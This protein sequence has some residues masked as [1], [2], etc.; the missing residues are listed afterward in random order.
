MEY[1]VNAINEG[2][3]L[4]VVVTATGSGDR[5]RTTVACQVTNTA[6]LAAEMIRWHRG[7]DEERTEAAERLLAGAGLDSTST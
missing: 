6:D 4:V 5:R 3:G 1:R 2:Q 7:S